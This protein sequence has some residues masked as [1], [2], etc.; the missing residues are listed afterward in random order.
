MVVRKH[1]RRFRGKRSQSHVQLLIYIV[2]FFLASFLLIGVYCSG[3]IGHPDR[4]IWGSIVLG[5]VLAVALHY[6]FLFIDKLLTLPFLDEIPEGFYH[7]AEEELCAIGYYRVS[8]KVEIAIKNIMIGGIKGKYL[9]VALSSDI[10]GAAKSHIDKKYYHFGPSVTGSGIV[11][12][13]VHYKIGETEWKSKRETAQNCE[14]KHE[15]GI[16]S[17]K[18]GEHKSETVKAYYDLE[19][20]KLSYGDNHVWQSP[21]SGGFSVHFRLPEYNCNA[22]IKRGPKLEQI[23][24]RRVDGGSEHFFYPKSL[25]SNQSFYW[26]I[27]KKHT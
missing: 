5:G 10:V 22:E 1:W 26:S 13:E 9:E 7:A 14:H 8:T 16:I 4:K 6:F 2:L 27:K 24:D 21:V 25:F 11:P 18:K 20:D 15:H 23:E 3:V 12:R 19:E 17:I